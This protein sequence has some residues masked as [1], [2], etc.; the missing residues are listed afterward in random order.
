VIEDGGRKRAPRAPVGATEA[1]TGAASPVEE[2]TLIVVGHGTYES[3]RLP[4]AGTVTLGRSKSCEIRI[5]HSSISRRHAT[6]HLGD[7]IE[8]EDLGSANG[9]RVRGQKLATGV[10][11]AVRPSEVID[12]GSLM[13]IAQECTAPLRR[14]RIWN[15][16]AFEERVD[17]EC[18]RAEHAAASFTVLRVT[19]PEAARDAVEQA[20]SQ[21]VRRFDVVGRYG[22]GEWEAIVLGS[23][24][25]GRAIVERVLAAAPIVRIGTASYPRDGRDSLSLAEAAVARVRGEEAPERPRVTAVSMPELERLVSR[26][27]EG[28]IS[29]LILGETGVGKELIAARIHELSSRRAGP[30]VRI[31]CAALSATLLESELFGHVKGAFTG[32]DRAKPGLLEAAHGGTV[33]LDEVGDLPAETQVKLL[34]V[35]EQREILP[36]GAV[37]PRAIDVRFLAATHRELEREIRRGAFR[38]DLYF[39]L[40]G[41]TLRIPPLRDRTDEIPALADTFLREAVASHDGRRLP[42]LSPEALRLLQRYPWPGN[43]RELR[44]AIERAVLLGTADTIEPEHLPIE[45]LRDDEVVYSRTPWPAE[46]AVA[47]PAPAPPAAASPPPDEDLDARAADLRVEF[48]RLERQRIL[49]ALD[50]CGGNQ[51]RA[52]QAL[53]ISRSKLIS[54]LDQ[55]GVPRPRK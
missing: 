40:A 4:D 49:R 42:T 48:D 29:V 7:G 27:A 18:A 34:R 50:D 31:N 43:I 32:A 36:V 51:T 12:V 35:L 16:D 3:F 38:Q 44:H 5:D 19:A 15:H 9:T 45:K 10:R 53:G 20:L 25:D 8:I 30:F 41:I 26:V 22:P 37:S 23:D 21:A 6:L 24:A 33:L 46:E 13:V 1:P 47:P 54:R 17:E 39:R 14:R 11:V 2:R 28:N 55:Y 52:A